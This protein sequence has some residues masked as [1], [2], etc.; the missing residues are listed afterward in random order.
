MVDSIYI[1][2]NL[3]Y[4]ILMIKVALITLMGSL[5]QSFSFIQALHTKKTTLC[6]ESQYCLWLR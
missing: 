2:E 4:K 6:L 3:S 1:L 5:K